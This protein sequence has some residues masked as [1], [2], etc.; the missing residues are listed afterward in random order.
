MF[1]GQIPVTYYQTNYN[2][3]YKNI[4]T[5]LVLFNIRVHIRKQIIRIA[6]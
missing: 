3:F 4:V 6:L 5:K 2:I 1:Y